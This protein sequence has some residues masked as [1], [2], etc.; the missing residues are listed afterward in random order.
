MNAIS[1]CT[2]IYEYHCRE[3]IYDDNTVCE[4]VCLFYRSSFTVRQLQLPHYRSSEIMAVS[5]HES[6]INLVI[7]VIYR[8]GSQQADTTFFED[9]SDLGERVAAMSAPVIMLGDINIH[10]DDASLS[11]TSNF[12][13]IVTSC[14]MQQLV[15][16][17]THRAGH[18]LDVVIVHNTTSA[19]VVI[20]PPVISDHSVITV[21][22]DVVSAR[23][24]STVTVT[25][26][27]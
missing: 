23:E 7:V 26:R 16:G 3:L 4:G 5:I 10:I 11:S 9:F 14:G 15:T 12:M 1:K 21:T 18:T 13:D 20:E 19:T 22:V 8:P 27:D 6:G 25:K 2:L 24:T 17:P